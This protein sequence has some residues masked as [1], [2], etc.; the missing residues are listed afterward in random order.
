MFHR[1]G[2]T[3]IVKPSLGADIAEDGLAVLFARFSGAPDVVDQFMIVEGEV[4]WDI[5][6]PFCQLH[7]AAQVQL[8]IFPNA[9]NRRHDFRNQGGFAQA[10]NQ[11]PSFGWI[12]SQF[13]I[14]PIAIHDVKVS[15]TC[16][17]LIE[18]FVSSGS[19]PGTIE[20]ILVRARADLETK[21]EQSIGVVFVIFRRLFVRQ[22]QKRARQAVWMVLDPNLVVVAS[23]GL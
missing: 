22:R 2:P 21:V 23:V 13:F 17:V 4:A 11:S 10:L 5:A 9:D 16:P 3:Q 12:G 15:F 8:V 6:V 20:W 19:M 1:I 14:Q 18:M 7:S